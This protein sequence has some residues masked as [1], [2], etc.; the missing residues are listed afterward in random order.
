MG[1]LDPLGT[2][3]LQVVGQVRG[4]GIGVG[5]EPSL[6]SV[7]AD[8]AGLSLVD[9]TKIIGQAN[10]AGPLADDVVG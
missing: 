1:T 4:G 3:S 6:N 9:D 5:T 7:V 8:C 10:Q 2:V